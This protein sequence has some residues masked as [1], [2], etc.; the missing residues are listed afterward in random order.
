MVMVCKR[1]GRDNIP[2]GVF[3]GGSAEGFF[4]LGR[5]DFSWCIGETWCAFGAEGEFRDG[6]V[7]EFGLVSCSR[8]LLHG[9]RPESDQSCRSS[10]TSR[11]SVFWGSSDRRF[12]A[13]CVLG[14]CLST[15]SLR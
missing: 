5:E 11:G 3:H 15:F 12:R 8:T 10:R 2:A 9:D 13:G 1:R 6:A 14:V 7:L 4:A